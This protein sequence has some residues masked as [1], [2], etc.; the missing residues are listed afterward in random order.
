MDLWA[1][2]RV[3]SADDD[4]QAVLSYAANSPFII[5]F[6]KMFG[7]FFDNLSQSTHYY[8]RFKVTGVGHG[9][10]F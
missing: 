1:K 5:Y 3:D 2:W 8:Q 6:F 7:K 4:T 10:K 9:F